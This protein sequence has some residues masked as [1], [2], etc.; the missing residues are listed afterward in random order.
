MSP[1]LQ[2]LSLIGVDALTDADV[3]LTMSYCP[4]NHSFHFQ[5]LIT[6]LKAD[7]DVFKERHFCGHMAT[8]TH[9]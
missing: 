7:T 5:D 2:E 1:N 9:V 8:S 3:A 4:L 6:P